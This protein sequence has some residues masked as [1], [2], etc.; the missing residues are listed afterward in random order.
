MVISGVQA[1]GVTAKDVLK[2][3]HNHEVFTAQTF[4]VNKNIRGVANVNVK[5]NSWEDAKEA[6]SKFKGSSEAKL[7]DQSVEVQN[8][9]CKFRTVL[10]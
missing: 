8:S 3:F 7:A 4:K 2:M 10:V 9:C 6:L 5:M 1:K